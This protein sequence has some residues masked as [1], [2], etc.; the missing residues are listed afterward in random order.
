MPE[1][2]PQ[3]ILAGIST[4]I[5]SGFFGIGGGTV[6]VP[7]LIFIGLEIK[8]A[9][10]ISLIQMVMASIYGSYINSKNKLI[11]LNLIL[12]IGV[13]GFLGALGSVFFVQSV[14]NEFLETLFLL[15]LF[16]AIYRVWKGKKSLEDDG[17]FSP[18]HKIVLVGIGTMIGFFA[19]SI[20]VGGSLLLVPILVGFF[21][22][23]IKKAIATGLFFVIFSSVAG[24]ISFSIGSEI[25]YEDGI[26][27]GFAS[28]FGVRL[29]IWLGQ[30]SSQEL[31]KKLLLIFYFLIASY[32]GL[33][34]FQII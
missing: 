14:S 26:L 20:G 32:M 21:H 6:L 15:F 10:G 2:D 27:V 17:E 5:I 16:F 28:L 23:D 7:M 11:D 29:G 24:V 1:L 18:P 3:M 22:Y 34:V 12:P 25:L 9:I 13:G 8:D 31:Q 33:R 4:G 30:K 19:I